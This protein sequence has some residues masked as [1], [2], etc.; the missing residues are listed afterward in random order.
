MAGIVS[1]QRKRRRVPLDSYAMNEDSEQDRLTHLAEFHEAMVR[2]IEP[3][4]RMIRDNEPL[5]RQI[6]QIES[7]LSETVR[8]QV[9]PVIQATEQLVRIASWPK[10]WPKNGGGFRLPL[11]LQLAATVNAGIQELVP[12][13]RDVAIDGAPATVQVTVPPGTVTGTGGLPLPPMRTS[14]KGTAEKR[15]KGPAALSDGEIVALVLVWLYAF[16]LPW[17]ATR[18]PPEWHEMVS[19]GYATV[20]IALAI[21]WRIID[22]HE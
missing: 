12:V 6:E 2:Q 11:P 14:G 7:M 18:L 22:K 9:E 13:A 5:I 4:V 16:A 19:D 10:N 3:I 17:F 20:A 1:G 21:T 15:P 8:L